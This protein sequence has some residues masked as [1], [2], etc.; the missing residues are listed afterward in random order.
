MN[1]LIHTVSYVTQEKWRAKENQYYVFFFKKK[2]MILKEKTHTFKLQG[3][4]WAFQ[5][6][7]L[8]IPALKL[9]NLQHANYRHV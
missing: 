9:N 5:L 4:A 1:Q 3:Q 6:H 8:C 2:N 7:C